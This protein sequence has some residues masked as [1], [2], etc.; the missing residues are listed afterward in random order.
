MKVA[1]L[2]SDKPR[3]RILADAFLIG[4]AKHG[5]QVAAFELGPNE[6]EPG[7]QDVVCLV[8]VKSADRVRAHR[9]A[10]SHV[11]MLDKGYNR[12]RLGA[13][14]RQ[15]EHWRIAVDSHHPT[16]RLQLRT[17]PGDRWEALQMQLKPWRTV[18][19]A[20]HIVLAG[21]SAKYH[22]YYGLK[23]PT[24]FARNVVSQLRGLTQ[25][26]LV[27]RPK[28][29]WSEATPVSKARFSRPPERIHD[30]LVNCHAM[31][32]HG[33]NACFEALVAGVPTIVLGDGVVK[34]ISSTDLADIEAPRLASYE[35]RLQLVAGLAYH[36]YTTAEF[37]RGVGW[38]I[39][40]EELHG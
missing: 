39:I 7:S 5:H 12:A 17:W 29:S 18:T 10:G 3:E 26:P 30:V 15:W 13:K 22:A 40:A 16:N 32:T 23:H 34:P 33:S 28:P 8:G 9:H 35:E 4:A 38:Q 31:V 36:Q 27:Y 24:T 6:P 25:R 14:T 20:G 2:H 19:A 1:F 37:A 21:S 11:I